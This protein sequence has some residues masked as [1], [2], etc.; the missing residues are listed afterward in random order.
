MTELSMQVVVLTATVGAFALLMVFF[1]SWREDRRREFRL[2]MDQI[3]KENERQAKEEARREEAEDRARWEKLDERQRE[4]ERE[5]RSAAGAGTG[6]YIILDLPDEQRR[7]FHDLLKGF[8]DYAKLK[9]YSVSF[10]IDATFEKRIAF[11]F[12]VREGG[13]SVGQERVRSDFKEYLDKIKNAEQIDDLPVVVS[14]EE[15]ELL[16]TLLKNRINFLQH[17]YNLAKNT[18]HYYEALIRKA[19]TMPVFPSQ[20]I[21]LQTGGSFDSRSYQ[22]SHS[23]RLIQGDQNA[24]TDQSVDASIRIGNSFNER[25]AQLDALQGLISVLKAAEQSSKTEGVIRPLE[26]ARQEL[27]EE[28]APDKS[29]IAR[30]LARAKET[31]KLGSFAKEAIDAAKDLFEQFGLPW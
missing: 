11:K 28:E 27:E 6:G 16:V 22:S 14:I 5:V 25:R 30:W 24:L 1:V 17:S 26:R 9:G 15:H 20:Q 23:S 2:R 31:L 13:L 21:L 10:S 19:T 3:E 18:S 8:E 7:F 4:E 29:R 12:N